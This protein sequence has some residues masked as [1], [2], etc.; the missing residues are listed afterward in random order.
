MAAMS[1][2][3]MMGNNLKNETVVAALEPALVFYCSSSGLTVNSERFSIH[4]S[5]SPPELSLPRL[6]NP[7][8]STPSPLYLPLRSSLTR[9]IVG[10]CAD[11]RGFGPCSRDAVMFSGFTVRQHVLGIHRIAGISQ[12][13]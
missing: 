2:C 6:T 12:V 9:C 8:R 1:S 5:S 13:F 11:W 7:I 4:L 3:Y 10:V